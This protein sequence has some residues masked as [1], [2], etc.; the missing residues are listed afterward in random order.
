[1]KASSFPVAFPSAV[2]ATRWAFR[3]AFH[4]RNWHDDPKAPPRS[5]SPALVVGLLLAADP[6]DAE[7]AAVTRWA[8]RAGSKAAPVPDTP[9]FRSAMAKLEPR[10]REHHALPSLPPSRS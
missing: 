8:L 9:A 1:M 6:T 7:L 10:L 3:L 5:V 4:P 2:E